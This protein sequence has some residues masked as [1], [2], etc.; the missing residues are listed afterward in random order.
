MSKE[1][2]IDEILSRSHKQADQKKKSEKSG[3]ILDSDTGEEMQQ[4]NPSKKSI[5]KPPFGGASAMPGDFSQIFNDPNIMKMFASGNMPG[6][7]SLPLKQRIM[8]K[9]MGFFAKPGRIQMVKNKWLWPIWAVVL[10]ILIAIVAVIAVFFL[11]FRLLKALIMPYIN[12]FRR[13]S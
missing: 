3:K 9:L 10:I 13:K 12:I 2:N 11:L 4:T 8:F 5:S 7:K 1:V 6:M